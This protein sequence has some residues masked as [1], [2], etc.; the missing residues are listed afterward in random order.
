M[1]LLLLDTSAVVKWF[2]QENYSDFA[3]KIREDFYNG[4][5]EIIIPD[6]L[7]YEFTNALRYNPNYSAEDVK[8]ALASIIEMELQIV[9]PTEEM[10]K[11]AVD[12]A[13]KYDITIYDAV[14]I[15][16]GRLIGA[17]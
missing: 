8:K 9:M 15:S 14:F 5:H 2:T 6:L 12:L 7:I 10:L 16:L 4:V 17:N 1:A 3:I 13:K 11:D